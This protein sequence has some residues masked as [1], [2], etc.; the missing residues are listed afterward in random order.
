MRKHMGSALT[1]AAH[2][3]ANIHSIAQQL[4]LFGVAGA[5]HKWYPCSCFSMKGLFAL[6]PKYV[7]LRHR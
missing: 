5:P 3:N 7:I 2:L 4:S 6:K 1:I